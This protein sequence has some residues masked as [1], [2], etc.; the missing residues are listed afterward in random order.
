[1]RTSLVKG[2]LVVVCIATLGSGCSTLRRWWYGPTRTN[3]AETGRDNL[4]GDEA[5]NG[6]GPTSI[7]DP[8]ADTG[9][10]P[11]SGKPWSECRTVDA[12]AVF[13][14]V[15]FAYDS[16]I[17]P[18][19]E[20]AKIDDVAKFLAENPDRVVNVDGHCDERGSNEYN[21]SLGEQRAQSVR[22]YLIATGIDASRIQTRSFGKEK[23]LDPGHSEAAW[24]KNRRGE[25]VIYK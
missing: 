5:L 4:I 15:R 13:A 10:R 22:T 11:M 20:N 12:N 18:P 16:F 19:Q 7:P 9:D 25:F 23:P 17:L 21:L 2:L 1:M 3:T 14:A 6:N 24:A 8:N